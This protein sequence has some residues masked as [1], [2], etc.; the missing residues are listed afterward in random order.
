MMMRMNRPNSVDAL[1]FTVAVTTASWFFILRDKLL[2]SSKRVARENHSCLQSLRCS[3]ASGNEILE[4]VIVVPTDKPARAAVLICHGIGETVD[5]WFGVQRLLAVEGVA[6]LVFDYSGYGRSTGR[7]RWQQCEQDAVAAFG[8]LKARVPEIPISILGFSLGSGIAVAAIDRISPQNLILCSSFSEFQAAVCCVGLPRALRHI[9]PPIWNTKASLR[10]CTLPVLVLHC[11]DDR[12]FPT[13]MAVDVASG[14]SQGTKLVIV[15]D[16]RH[17]DPFRRPQFEFW[18][19]VIS[20]L[21]SKRDVDREC[22]I[23]NEV[24]D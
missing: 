1:A 8:A 12:L 6:S 11:E 15:R 21:I 5:H 9:A 16:H 24:G 13:E 23:S 19:H 20:L 7:I 3:I 18:Q 14:C 10:G 4:A 17:N 22:M 2:G